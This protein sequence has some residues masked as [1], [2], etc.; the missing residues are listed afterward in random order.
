[1]L[2]LFVGIPLI[3]LYYYAVKKIRDWRVPPIIFGLAATI[4]L[5]AFIAIENKDGDVADMLACVSGL[6]IICLFLDIYVLLKIRKEW[7]K[8]NTSSYIGMGYNSVQTF[9]EFYIDDINN[10]HP[11]Y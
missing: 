1:M 10:N 7:I 2:K 11:S 9:N 6:S 5:P 3:I 4:T 8:Y